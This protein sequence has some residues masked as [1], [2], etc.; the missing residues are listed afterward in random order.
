MKPPVSRGDIAQWL[1]LHTDTVRRNEHRLGLDAA[2]A[3][4]GN[5]RVRYN[6]D[7]AL[8]ILIQKRLL[9]APVA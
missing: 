2:R 1:G 9:S 8:R 6:H 3:N 4:T 7:D 5:H